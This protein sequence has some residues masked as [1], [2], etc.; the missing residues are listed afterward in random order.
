MWILSSLDLRF[1]T[2]TFNEYVSQYWRENIILIKKSKY[3]LWTKILIPFTF[4]TSL[5]VLALIFLVK[6]VSDYVPWLFWSLIVLSIFLWIVL[7]AKVIKYF[8]DYKM[9]F[10]ILN[11]RSFIRFDQ[12]GLFKKVSKTID[13]RKVRSISVRKMWFWNSLFNNWTLVIVSEWW[14]AEEDAKLRAW[15]IMF[16]DVYNPEAYN[17]K[18]N[19]FLNKAFNQ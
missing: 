13:L 19:D 2:K 7:N 3:F 16:N 12:D 14:E 8:L 11:P 10:I 1:K 5:L 6:Y 4:W 9:D 15:E 17:K 18:I